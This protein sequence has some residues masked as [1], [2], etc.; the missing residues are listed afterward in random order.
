MA[1]KKPAKDRKASRNKTYKLSPRQQRVAC[2]LLGTGYSPQI[3]A[4][5]LFQDHGV[6][7]S[8]KGIA[9]YRDSR[10]W[11][12]LIRRIQRYLR[13]KT[14]QHPVA[15]KVNRLDYLNRAI[16]IALNEGSAHLSSLVREARIETEGEK[17]LI[18]VGD[19][20][21]VYLPEQKEA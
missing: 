7:I 4:D 18:E 15:Q 1:K 13:R 3:V 19:T 12:D 9:K 11:K 2:S 10:K 14:I 17:A 8:R 6:K 20:L 21:V 5:I 16:N